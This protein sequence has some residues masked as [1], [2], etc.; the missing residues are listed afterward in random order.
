MENIP[1]TVIDPYYRYK[2]SKVDLIPS[3]K[4]YVWKNF[5]EICKQIH[6]D[7]RDI[8][9]KIRKTLCQNMTICNEGLKIKNTNVHDLDNALEKYI[10]ENILCR[11]CR[12]PE[13]KNN[14]CMACGDYFK[15]IFI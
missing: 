11:K 2:R 1:K 6:A 8:Y 14:V 10:N 13:L 5:H 15:L 3:G 9:S 12:L 7:E 4:Y